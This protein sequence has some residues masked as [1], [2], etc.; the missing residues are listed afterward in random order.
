MHGAALVRIPNP[1]AKSEATP[2]RPFVDLRNRLRPAEPAGC[3][4]CF[5]HRHPGEGRD[6]DKPKDRLL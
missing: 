4:G 3:V 5:L 6:P 2:S 1:F